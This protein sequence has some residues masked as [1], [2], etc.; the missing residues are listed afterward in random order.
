MKTVTS[1]YMTQSNYFF[2]GSTT[3]ALYD[4]TCLSLTHGKMDFNFIS[5]DYLAKTHSSPL[6]SVKLHYNQDILVKH[7]A[8]SK[9]TRVTGPQGAQ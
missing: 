2:G 3:Y 1:L 7:H 8:T 6:Q 4:L 5:F 9:L